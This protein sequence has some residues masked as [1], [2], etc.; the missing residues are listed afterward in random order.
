MEEGCRG[1]HLR[2]VNPEAAG[3]VTASTLEGSEQHT[4][5]DVDN[6]GRGRGT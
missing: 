6:P 1:I 4:T 5:S 3:G 2:L